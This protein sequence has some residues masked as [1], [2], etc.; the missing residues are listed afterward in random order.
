MVGL[1]RQYTHHGRLIIKFLVLEPGQRKR[2]ILGDMDEFADLLF[3]VNGCEKMQF[4]SE[5]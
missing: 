3:L 1:A 2:P 5:Q 4:E